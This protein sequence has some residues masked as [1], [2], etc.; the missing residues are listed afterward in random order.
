MLKLKFLVSIFSPLE[1]VLVKLFLS[2]IFFLIVKFC[3]A[4]FIIHVMIYIPVFLLTH[5][6][7]L[8]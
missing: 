1:T 5:I 2:W 7:L 3:K 8:I 4:N 6:K